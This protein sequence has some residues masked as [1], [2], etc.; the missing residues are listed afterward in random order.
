MPVLTQKHATHR[1]IRLTADLIRVPHTYVVVRA[2]LCRA[3]T[4]TIGKNIDT[5]TLVELRET[6]CWYQRRQCQTCHGF[7]SFI[8]SLEWRDADE[9]MDLLVYRMM[10]APITSATRWNGPRRAE[11]PEPFMFAITRVT[12]CR[13][14]SQEP[15]HSLSKVQTVAFTTTSTSCALQTQIQQQGLYA[16]ILDG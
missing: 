12:S 14:S 7:D 4:T 13:C 11:A 8:D 5:S 9:C 10:A 3:H 2:H 6:S 1:W 15:R 16:H